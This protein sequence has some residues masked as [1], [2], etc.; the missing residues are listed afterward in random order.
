MAIPPQDAAREFQRAIRAHRATLDRLMDRRGLIPLK[1]SFDQL[2]D[3]LERLM[4]KRLPTGQKQALTPLQAQ[5][6][7]VQVRDA[8]L[9]IAKRLAR[10]LS[11]VIE[12]AQEEGIDQTAQT[13]DKLE[14]KFH[15]GWLSVPV[16]EEATKRKLVEAR[17]GAL[18]RLN[19]TA[20]LAVGAAL[21]TKQQEAL[22][23][24]LA[25]EE[26]PD[27]AVNR[28][29]EA[30]DSM[31]WKAKS[32]IQ[33]GLA[34]GFNSGQAGAV[35]ELS[36]VAPS[37]WA[38]R[39]CEL[40]DDATGMP[41]DNKVGNDSMALHGQIADPGGVFVMPEDPSV[42]PWFWNRAWDSSPNRPHDRSVTMAIRLSWGIPGYRLI[43]GQRVPVN[44][45]A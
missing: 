5:Q 15:G 4:V 34:A 43:N 28:M 13:T 11:P 10:S 6:L 7:L 31:W 33:T 12:E 21:A 44:R 30:A 8:Q 36:A 3:R 17:S 39:W 24:S 42:H 41:F 37:D 38:K 32:A 14:R 2:Q 19:E 45:A 18:E 20:W 16:D 23:I 35:G 25:L 40:V 1:R 29:R 9:A 27:E 26:M 22:S